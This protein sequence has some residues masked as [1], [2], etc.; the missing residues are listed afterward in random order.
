L[1]DGSEALGRIGRVDDVAADGAGH[2]NSGEHGPAADDQAAADPGGGVQGER[3]GVRV[4]EADNEG[5]DRLVLDGR[6]APA[7]V[8]VTFRYP[9]GVFGTAETMS[10]SAWAATMVRVCVGAE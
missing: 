5:A 6:V 2:V 1:V 10:W 3:A 7:W 8:S 9:V 4:P